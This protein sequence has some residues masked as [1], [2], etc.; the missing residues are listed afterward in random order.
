MDYTG[1]LNLGPT[2]GS[3]PE[4]LETIQILA[5]MAVSTNVGSFLWRAHYLGS[6]LEP[7]TFGNYHIEAQ[8]PHSEIRVGSSQSRCRPLDPTN[9]ATSEFFVVP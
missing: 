6:I 1:N 8:N 7:L 4:S 9:S 2:F 5:D 3:D